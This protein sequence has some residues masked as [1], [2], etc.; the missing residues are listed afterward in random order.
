MT[1]PAS[2]W[3]ASFGRGALKF[4]LRVAFVLVLFEGTASLVLFTLELPRQI[5]VPADTRRHTEHDPELDSAKIEELA[6]GRIFTARQAAELGLIDR[7]GHL[8]QA[9][10]AVEQR[11]GAEESRVVVYARP[12][13]Y[14]SNL[15]S[16]R[17]GPPVQ[18]VDIDLLPFEASRLEPGFYYLWPPALFSR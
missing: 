16:R 3:L 6:D 10:R 17:G 5:R 12:S 4:S 11:I 13:E 2:S 18:L 8:E 14:R 7:V 1:G 15:Y 9:V